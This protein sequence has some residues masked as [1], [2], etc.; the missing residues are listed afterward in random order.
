MT[1]RTIGLFLTVA[2]LALS[3]CS[4]SGFSEDPASEAGTDTSTDISSEAAGQSPASDVA[5]GSDFPLEPQGVAPEGAGATTEASPMWS[6]VG[7]IR[8]RTTASGRLD[9]SGSILPFEDAVDYVATISSSQGRRMISWEPASSGSNPDGEEESHSLEKRGEALQGTFLTA[10]GGGIPA[11]DWDT[12]PVYVPATLSVGQRWRTSARG[13]GSYGS[14]KT[15]DDL[16]MEVEVEGRA[17]VVVAGNDVEV[18]D[19]RRIWTMSRRDSKRNQTYTRQAVQLD[20]YAP[21]L[22]FTVCS[23]TDA[24]DPARP[25]GAKSHSTAE[26]AEASACLP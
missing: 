8:F 13:V 10:A 24:R 26:L 19:L 14:Y 3:A 1:R 15:S 5:L 2:A 9:V 21:S 4:E 20:R 23:V 25:D 6:A 16:S 12:P 17:I 11:S 22:G 18:F 7:S